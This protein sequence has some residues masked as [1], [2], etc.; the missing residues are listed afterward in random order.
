LVGI[1]FGRHRVWSASRLV[2]IAFGRH[3]VWSAAPVRRARGAAAR[4]HGGVSARF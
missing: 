4:A 3:R 1:A 2:G